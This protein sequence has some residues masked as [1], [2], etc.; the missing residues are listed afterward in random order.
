MR[1]RIGQ[2]DGGDH[3]VSNR[4]QQL[5][6]IAGWAL[7]VLWLL[8]FVV[9]VDFLETLELK[10]YDLRYRLMPQRAVPHGGHL[11]W[12]HLSICHIT[13]FLCILETFSRC[14]V[15]PRVCKSIA[16]RYALAL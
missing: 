5:F 14:E 6:R 7:P 10:T 13:I 11:C 12:R 3:R 8:L 2:K 9:G 16:L 1:F 4:G 15:R